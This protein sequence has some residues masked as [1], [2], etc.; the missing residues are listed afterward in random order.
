MSRL[1]LVASCLLL[2]VLTL[3]LSSPTILAQAGKPAREPLVEEVRKGIKRGVQFLKDQ[4]QLPKGHWELDVITASRPGGETALVLLALLNCGE[5]PTDPVIAR[6]LEYLRQVPPQDTYVVGLQ[7]MVL[8]AA[9]FDKDQELIQRNVDWLVKARVMAGGQLMGWGY[10]LREGGGDNS[11]TQYALLGLHDGH[12]AGAKI[13]REVWESIQNF[14]IRT[15]KQDGSWGYRSE[16]NDGSRLTMTTAGV[17][18]LYIAGFELNDRRETFLR[19]GTIEGCGVYKENVPVQKALDWIGR[20]FNIERPVKGFEGPIFYN[21][22]GIERT[23]R[24]SGERF[25]GGHDW[26]REGCLFL[27]RPGFQREDGAWATSR[28]VHDS[29]AIIST[30]FALLF[31]SKGRTPILI[32]KLAHG[33]GDD[34]NNDRNDAR[35][36]VEYAGR[37][38]FKRQPVAWQIFNP[39]KTNLEENRA[40]LL[41][42]VADLLQSPIAYFNGHQAPT[43]S[44]GEKRLLKEYLDQG[45][46]I[47]AEACCGSAAFDKGFRK[48]VEDRENQGGLDLELKP[49][50]PE[51]PI[52]RAHALIDDQKTFPL[53]GVQQGCK[54]V[55]VYCPKDLSCYWE[56][57]KLDTPEGQL[58][59]RIGGNIIA[60]ATGMELPKPRLTPVD[61]IDAKAQDKNVTRGFLQVGQIRHEGDWQPAP[62]AMRNLM[63]HLRERVKLDVALQTEAIGLGNDFAV[64]YKFLYMHGRNAFS[65]SDEGR[66]NLQANLMTHGLLLADACCGKKEFDASFRAEM[67]KVFPDKKLEPISPTDY[68]YSKELNGV[69]IERVR[70]RREL[71]DGRPEPEFKDVP[72][73]LEGIKINGRW[74]VI[75]SKYDIGCALEKHRST[76][77]KGHDH[78][79]AL[80]LGAAAVLYFL[81]P[82]R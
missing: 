73:F 46:F 15:Q 40:E 56:S 50:P 11:N 75:Y 33:P 78:D 31:L 2:G 1:S 14:Y 8:A 79:S 29:W 10:R 27:T 77:C 60:Y 26:Y 35:N 67:E 63:A 42:T 25:L 23:G 64:N 19:N 37:E 48:L 24:L 81:R 16:G 62:R 4:Q 12:Q 71:P 3:G 44:P 5:K 36:L 72:P 66:K 70:C 47:L 30:S 41:D 54:T 34:W 74:V 39:A 65:F 68:L 45:G 13:D 22:Y 53:Y 17:C 58:A 57:K 21:L 9:G 43:F 18:G 82:V 59:F 80:R 51:H 38:V 55:L 52:W 61:V 7:T 76:D 20:N 49:L 6:G 69:A 28:G 32:S